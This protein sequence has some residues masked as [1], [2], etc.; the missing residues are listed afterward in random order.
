MAVLFL[1]GA[2]ASVAAEVRS[3]ALDLRRGKRGRLHWTESLGAAGVGPSQEVEMF[4]RKAR[5]VGALGVVAVLSIPIAAQSTTRVS[6]NSSGI[7]GNGESLLGSCSGDGRFIAFQSQADNFYDGDLNGVSD[8]FVHDRASGDLTL[9]SVGLAGRSANGQSLGPRVSADGRY[10][11]FCSDAT[12]LV[13][14]DTNG[15][16]DVFVRDRQANTTTR[17]SVDSNGVQGDDDSAS[18]MFL[19]GGQG[20]HSPYTVDISADGRFVAFESLATNL[21]T[22][23]GNGVN[24]IFVHDMLTGITERVSLKNDGAENTHS[25]SY[26]R[27]SGDGK[28]VLFWS[29]GH[30]ASSDINNQIDAFV[31]DRGTAT[32][33]H[34]SIPYGT[35][36]SLY[37]AFPIDISADGR[38]VMFTS[39][40]NYVAPGPPPTNTEMYVR[41]LTLGVTSIVSLANSGAVGNNY[42]GLD[43]Q[44]AISAD[45]RFVAFDSYASNLVANDNNNGSDLFVRDRV[46]GTT[47]RIDVSSSGLQS[48]G[49]TRCWAISEDGRFV[50]VQADPNVSQLVAGDT[51]DDYDVIVR[52]RLSTCPPITSYCSAKTNS[53]GCAPSI[54]ASGEPLLT[55]FDAFFLSATNVL[56]QQRGLFFWSATSG[57][58]PFGGGYRCVLEPLVRTPTQ[59]SSGGSAVID[60]TGV[61]SFHFD[62]AYMAAHSIGAGRTLYGQFWSVDPGFAGTSGIGLTDA[63]RFTPTP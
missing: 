40:N 15:V 31:R 43:L 4:E 59:N 57:A 63:I 3:I 17:V 21:V 1:R 6:V 25:A 44:G 11:V 47:E 45:G 51:N 46:A 53:A 37:P 24:D 13:P 34:V 26:A 18:A 7:Q 28:R 33:I 20:H 12:D 39:G 52:D 54:S 55:G 36:Q 14:A 22:G 38:Y 42:S 56:S 35:N 8:I 23:D 30:F 5:C 61:Y 32:T 49:R 50:V 48:F 41:D 29:L 58:V 9:I 62:Q 19:G 60:C 16:R 10:V 2:G 27:I